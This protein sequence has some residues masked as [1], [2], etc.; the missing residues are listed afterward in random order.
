MHD[1]NQRHNFRMA[2]GELR[3]RWGGLESKII[4]FV[5][6]STGA[7]ASVTPPELDASWLSLCPNVAD[8][9]TNLLLRPCVFEAFIWR[10]LMDTIFAQGSH[11]WAGSLGGQLFDL[12]TAAEGK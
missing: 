4:Q 11:A 7:G 2:D 1:L 5:D 10:R 3:E 9:L 6:H 12:S 8:L